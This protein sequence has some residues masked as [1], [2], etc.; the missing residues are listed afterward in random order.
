MKIAYTSDLHIDVS[1]SNREAALI[2]AEA[3]AEEQPDV[4]VLAGDVGNTLDDLRDTLAIFEAAAVA[5]LFV[6][7]N[8][9]VWIETRHGELLDSRTKYQRLIPE[10]CREMGFHDLGR[11]PV[12]AG[13][14]GFA[15]SL[16]WYDY[17][18]ADP[19]LGLDEGAYW[20]GRYE[21]EIWWDRKMTYWIGETAAPGQ[22]SRKRM[23]DPEVCSELVRR[24]DDHLASIEDDVEQI[25]AVV[26]TLPFLA[27]LPRSEPPYYLDAYT[28]SN[29]LGDTLMAHPKVKHMIGGHKHLSGDW[30]VEGIQIHRRILGRIEGADDMREQAANAFGVLAI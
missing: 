20:A 19:R 2:I 6:P 5:K 8:H 30:E 18:F 4:F 27:G 3:V 13:S 24:L 26:H 15:G 29:R 10:L 22:T 9:D 1:T 17:S 11:E 25:V 28:G 7:G 23:R 14:I 21:N 12:I 16:G